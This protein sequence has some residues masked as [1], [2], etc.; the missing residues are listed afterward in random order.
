MGFVTTA[1]LLSAFF[2]GLGFSLLA[3]ARVLPRRLSVLNVPVFLG[4]HAFL[5]FSL[6]IFSSFSAIG[7]EVEE[8]VLSPCENVV[9]NS[10]E[11][12]STV[13]TYEY[14]NSCAGDTTPDIVLALFYATGSAM[15]LILLELIV[16]LM[17]VAVEW[18]RIKW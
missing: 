7:Y 11:L 16:L 4:I 3:L 5:F 10:T 14:V 13:V 8:V 1:F 2:I 12:N 6:A 17:I 15:A 9:S 18:L